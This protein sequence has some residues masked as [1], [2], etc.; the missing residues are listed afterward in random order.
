MKFLIVS[1]L[2]LSGCFLINHPQYCHTHGDCLN[3]QYC[4]TIRAPEQ[5]PDI[6]RGKAII[7]PMKLGD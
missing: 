7:T 2:L 6:C 3:G 4:P 1:S 5:P